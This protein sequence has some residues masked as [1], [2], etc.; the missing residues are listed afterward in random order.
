[1]LRQ[2]RWSTHGH[3]SPRCTRCSELLPP[4]PCGERTNGVR[5]AR[6]EATGDGD[7]AVVTQMPPQ[8]REKGRFPRTAPV[9]C[10][11]ECPAV[12]GV[13]LWCGALLPS[14]TPF[15]PSPHF[16]LGAGSKPAHE[17]PSPAMAKAKL[18]I[19]VNLLIKTYLQHHKPGLTPV[20]SQP[21]FRS[22]TRGRCFCI[23]GMR[24]TALRA[25]LH[26][27]LGVPVGDRCAT[28]NRALCFCTGHGNVCHG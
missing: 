26:T 16:V 10:L 27:H 14:I 24:G 1:M 8:A 11:E 12:W 2:P 3:T 18:Y 4:D 23:P 15:L 20:G 28:A 9:W 13:A 7:L 6:G 17:L 19:F 22:F 5:R 25:Q 21:G